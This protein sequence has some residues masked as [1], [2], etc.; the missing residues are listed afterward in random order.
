MKATDTPMH[1]EGIAAFGREARTAHAA[2]GPPGNERL[3]CYGTF[4][5]RLFRC[6]DAGQDL[7]PEVESVDMLQVEHAMKA[8]DKVIRLYMATIQICRKKN[9][10]GFSFNRVDGVDREMGVTHALPSAFVD[11][12][13]I[14]YIDENDAG[15]LVAEIMRKRLSGQQVI[16]LEHYDHH[17]E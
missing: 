12:A 2:C 5:H 14:P 4:H 13:G 6:E 17:P 15:N 16:F 1:V 9:F 10:A 3:Q 8:L 7:G 11:S